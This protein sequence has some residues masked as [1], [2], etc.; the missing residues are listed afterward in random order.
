M[1][2][3]TGHDLVNALLRDRRFGRVPPLG[4]PPIPLHLKDFYAA[5][6]FSLLDREPPEHTRI[7]GLVLRAFTSRRIAGMAGEIAGLADRLL[8]G[9]DGQ[10]IDLLPV[11]AER[12]PVIVI[13]RLL[14]VPEDMAPK[15]LQ[16]SHDMVA[17]YQA[18]RDKKVEEQAALSAR[19]FSDFL[20]ELISFRRGRPAGD[21]LTE[22]IAAE[23]DGDRLSTDEMISTAILLLNAGHE[24]TVHAI[25]N[26]VAAILSHGL[27][28]DSLFATEAATEALCTEVLRF[29]P[30]LHMFTRFANED[31]EIASHCFRRGDQ[32]GLLLAAANRD[33]RRYARPAALD[34]VR[35]GTG[36]VAFGAG[37]HY[38]LGAPL[39]LLEMAVALPRLFRR[40]PKLALA[41]PPVFAD[42]Y[43]F[44]GLERL[45]LDL[46]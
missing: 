2:C 36:H 25:G 30:P 32:V 8:E 11:F 9:L 28:P 34:P 17:M 41:G 27:P 29:D 44:R 19:E 20:K 26:G 13:A 40:Y 4:R 16:W 1:A 6:S 38:C 24:A 31:V 15:L 33:P 35:G 23:A 10:V 5:E 14:G 22:L 21:L 12:I 45:M 18:R 3:A 42:R 43:H 7:R 39:A 46:G 37:I